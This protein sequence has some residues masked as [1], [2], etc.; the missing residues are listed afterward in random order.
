MD[1]LTQIVLGA[2]V[3]EAILGKKEGN[4]AMFWGAYAGTLPDLDVLA[5]LA[6]DEASSLAYHRGITHS[7]FFSILMAAP[8]GILVQQLY[9]TG[10]PLRD[11]GFGAWLAI[12]AFLSWILFALGV[13]VLPIPTADT[14][15]I[16][17]TVMTAAML[18]VILYAGIRT[19]RPRVDPIVYSHWKGWAWLFF[20]SLVT[21]PLLDGFTTFGTQIFQP[22]TDYRHA[23]M[24]ISVVD[25]IYTIPFLVLLV[26]ARF[27]R[28]GHLRRKLLNRLGLLVSSMYLLFTVINRAQVKQ[29]FVQALEDQGVPYR[30]LTTGPTLGNNFLWHGVAEGDSVYYQGFYSIFDT[31]TA[32]RYRT[33]PKRWLPL[34]PYR[35]DRVVRILEWFSKGYY[36]IRETPEGELTWNDLRY[37]TLDFGQPGKEA[38]LFRFGLHPRPDG[39][40]ELTERGRNG[41]DDSNDFFLRFW[42]RMQ[43]RI[44]EPQE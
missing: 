9:R 36:T 23:T 28:K 12:T 38:Y 2:A 14:P 1:S 41:P 22:F 43:G 17:A 4:R 33:I 13:R 6:T 26:T 15:Y 32:I 10:H 24:S 31:T 25:P 35:D 19:V 44:L 27:Y 29:V 20:G 34:D 39:S 42:W 7:I 8:L 18:P 5:Q 16:A 3:G 21:H 11:R 40:L 37:G 30:Q